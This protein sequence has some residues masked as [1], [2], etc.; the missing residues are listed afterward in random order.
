[1]EIHMAANESTEEKTIDLSQIPTELLAQEFFKRKQEAREKREE[2]AYKKACCRNCAYR[3]YGKSQFNSSILQETWV[4]QKR[5]KTPR[6]I[7]GR[8]PEYNKAYYA[9]QKRYNGCKMFLHKD[10]PRGKKIVE[11]N[12]AMSFRVTD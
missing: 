6:N 5:P 3:I 8:V 7:F 12:K 9:C 1:M 2:L 4:C 10:S 11:K